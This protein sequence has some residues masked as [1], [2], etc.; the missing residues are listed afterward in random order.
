MNQR[1]SGEGWVLW[2]ETLLKDLQAEMFELAQDS[3]DKQESEVTPSVWDRRKEG[4]GPHVPSPSLCDKGSG[5]LFARNGDV[6]RTRWTGGKGR[7][8]RSCTRVGGWLPTSPKNQL[9]ALAHRVVRRAPMGK[10]RRAHASCPPGVQSPPRARAQRCPGPRVSAVT[11]ADYLDTHGPL[12]ADTAEGGG[13]WLQGNPRS[14]PDQSR[15][16]QYTSVTCLPLTLLRP[17]VK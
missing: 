9:C 17:L 14:A 1:P 4:L 11:E 6:R 15:C 10:A 12:G 5:S 13:R 3:R 2:R 16:D 7:A 8:G